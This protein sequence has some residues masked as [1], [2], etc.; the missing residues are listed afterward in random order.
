MYLCTSQS[1][2]CLNS[3]ES[4]DSKL[5]KIQQKCVTKETQCSHGCKEK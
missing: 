1:S 4:H 5:V 2:Y 3:A